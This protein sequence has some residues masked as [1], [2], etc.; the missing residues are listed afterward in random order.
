MPL[1]PIFGKLF[2]KILT[3]GEEDQ[4]RL[5]GELN[6]HSVNSCESYMGTK[7]FKI[8]RQIRQEVHTRLVKMMGLEEDE[9]KQRRQKD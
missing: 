2:V 4:R 8:T 1:P 9:Q 5:R 6:G 7:H 3:C